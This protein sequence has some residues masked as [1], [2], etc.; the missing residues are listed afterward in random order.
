MKEWKMEFGERWGYSIETKKAD[1]WCSL[2]GMSWCGE[3][4]GWQ[5][6]SYLVTRPSGIKKQQLVFIRAAYH[7][8]LMA[9]F[10]TSGTLN[11]GSQMNNESG[12]C[13]PLF[14]PLCDSHNFNFSSKKNIRL[15]QI[16][17]FDKQLWSLVTVFRTLFPLFKHRN[18][19][20]SSHVSS[21][22]LEKG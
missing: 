3:G 11:F 16:L 15:F 18:F 21:F 22:K 2:T 20:Y 14:I 13:F 12:E 1:L 7:S 10:P 4:L 9:V 5:L 6:S 19:I 8:L 17:C